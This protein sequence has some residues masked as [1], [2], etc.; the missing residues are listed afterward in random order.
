MFYFSFFRKYFIFIILFIKIKIHIWIV[1][2][3]IQVHYSVLF[4]IK[5]AFESGQNKVSYETTSV[6]DNFHV[7]SLWCLKVFVVPKCVIFNSVLLFCLTHTANRSCSPQEFTCI[8]NRPPQ[9]KC[10]PRDWVC[11]GDADC[12]DAYD[13]HQ[14][15]TR[16]SCSANEFTC[17]NG[18]CIRSSYRLQ[19]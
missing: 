2:S 18:L 13:E 17:S 19:L 4:Y 1:I 9:R 8:N 10:I 11:D 5:D 12:S 7:G 3:I 16:R 14:N 6:R 15:C